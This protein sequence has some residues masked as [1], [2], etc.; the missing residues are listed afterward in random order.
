[1]TRPRS[2]TTLRVVVVWAALLM[3]AAIGLPAAGASRTAQPA[4]VTPLTVRLFRLSPAT[5]PKKGR[6]V[7]AGSV[8]NDSQETWSAV[9]VHPFVSHTPM[10]TRDQLAAAA[11][12][13]PETEVGT[14]ITQAGL[15][16][17]VGDL[18]PGQTAR[19]TISIPRAD[20][21]IT[22]QAGVYWIGVH[23]LGQNAQGRDGLA[24]GRARTFIPL[25]QG[26]PFTS[27]ALVVPV[28]DRVSRDAEGRLLGTGDWSASLSTEGR[29]RRVLDFLG[30]AGPGHLSVL[31]DPSVLEAV[32]SVAADNPVLSLGKPTKPERTPSATPTGQT[33]RSEDRLEAS[34]RANAAAWL[35]GIKAQASAQTVLGLS[36]ADPDTSAL[37][38]YRPTLLARAG[39][40]ARETFDRLGIVA[41]PAVAPPDGWLD[42]DAL[43]QVPAGSM[44]LVSDHSAPRTRTQ[45]HTVHDQDLIFTDEQASAGG[46]GPTAPLDALALRQRIVSDAALRT[47]E[48]GTGPMVV[49]LPPN[50]NPGPAWRSAHFFDALDLPWLSLVPLSPSTDP[51]TPSF[52]AALGYPLSERKQEISKDNVV[53]AGDLVKTATVMNQLL[54]TTNT[55]EHTLSGDALSAVSYQAR[56]D[57]AIARDQVIAT[58][59]GMRDKLGEVEVT[60]TD[61]VTLSGGTGTVAVTL[62]NRLGQPITVGIRPHTGSADVRIETPKPLEMAPGERT[63]LRLKANASSIGVH[64]VTLTP[65]TTTGAELGTPLTFSLRTSQVGTLIWFVLAGGGLLLVVMIGRRILRGLREHRW[66]GQ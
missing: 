27:V 60:G 56:K 28:R 51:A 57:Q 45:W 21:P 12:S 39:R 16:A 63:V 10:T 17:A 31:L 14:R 42:D 23:A 52:D 19:F 33:S 40:I 26:T 7:L 49:E 35:S 55:L 25:V 29:L 4:T 54:R 38:R 1:V 13:D 65:V 3:L 20:L 8:R 24:D 36:F 61:F 44:V 50:W 41:L 6:I 43:T 62:V 47:G 59:S 11:A 30:S 2:T 9:N 22:G 34:D 37:A 18:A 46:P 66:R 58:D 5:I 53:A 15:F 64:E 32:E 48:G